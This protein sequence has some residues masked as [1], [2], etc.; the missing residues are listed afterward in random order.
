MSLTEQPCPPK[1]RRA[2]TTLGSHIIEIDAINPE[3]GIK[4]V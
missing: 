3:E 4:L 1:K 2:L